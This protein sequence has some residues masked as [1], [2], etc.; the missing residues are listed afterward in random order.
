MGDYNYNYSEFETADGTGWYLIGENAPA[1]Q[2]YIADSFGGQ[3]GTAIYQE[4]K[5]LAQ[6]WSSQGSESWFVP[7]SAHVIQLAAP[8][9]AAEP[10]L[11]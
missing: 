11:V 8:A 10:F 5:D 3:D 2:F 4:L 9:P 7:E 1:H 6:A